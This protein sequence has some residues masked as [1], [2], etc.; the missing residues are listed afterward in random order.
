M[1]SVG[2]MG[3]SAHQCFLVEWYQPD[4]ADV[5]VDTVIDRLA[6]AAADVRAKL[7]VVL[8]SP[9]DETLFAVVSGDAS[10]VVLAACRTADWHVDRI[11]A[12]VRAYLG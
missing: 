2:R 7:V 1:A 8:T 9:A 11:T 3:D 12:G 6:S 5:A 10:D 4:L